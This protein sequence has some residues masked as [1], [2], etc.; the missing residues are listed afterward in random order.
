MVLLLLFA[1]LLLFV[2]SVMLLMFRWGQR[3]L[4]LAIMGIVGFIRL[5][6][7]PRVPAQQPK[8]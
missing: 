6:F 7:P 8:L 3:A 4:G 5:F 1:F 2:G